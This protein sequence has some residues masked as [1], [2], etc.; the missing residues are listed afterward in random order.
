MARKLKIME[1]EKYKLDDLKN[2]EITKKPEK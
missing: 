1:I 2:D